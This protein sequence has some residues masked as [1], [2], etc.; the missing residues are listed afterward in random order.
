MECRP[1]VSLSGLVRFSEPDPQTH[2]R[3]VAVT[4]PWETSVVGLAVEEMGCYFVLRLYRPWTR[5]VVG[6]PV[7]AVCSVQVETLTPY[8][9][10]GEMMFF[11]YS[12]LSVFGFAAACAFITSTCTAPFS[13]NCCN[14][15]KC[16][17]LSC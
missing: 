2:Q 4:H 7:A 17:S 8:W 10:W 5:P 11:L 3:V 1:P 14:S 6:L 9:V 15:S 13:L 16:F 12:P